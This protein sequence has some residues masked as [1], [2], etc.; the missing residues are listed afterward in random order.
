MA[1][2]KGYYK[3]TRIRR[4]KRITQKGPLPKH[5]GVVV[6][7]VRSAGNGWF[8]IRWDGDKKASSAHAN[9]FYTNSELKRYGLA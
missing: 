6:S 7:G 2:L 8:K 5:S 4:G 9:W 1:I 3:L